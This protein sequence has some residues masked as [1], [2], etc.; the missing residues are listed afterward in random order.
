MAKILFSARRVA[1]VLSCAAITACAGPAYAPTSHYPSLPEAVPKPKPSVNGDL[2]YSNGS[3]LT[4]CHGTKCQVCK[5]IGGVPL[6]ISTSGSSAASSDIATG[7][8]VLVAD[9]SGQE[10]SEYNSSGT[11]IAV[12]ANP[13]FSAEDTAFGPNGEIAWT[14]NSSTSFGNGNITIVRGA[15]R[16]TVTGLFVN[17]YFGAFDKGGDFYNDGVTSSGTYPIGVVH[18]GSTTNEASKISGVIS[19]AGIAVALNGTVNIVDQSCLCIRIYKN[20]KPVGEVTLTGAAEP[21]SLALNRENTIV[22][23]TDE[24][25]GTVAAYPYPQGGMPVTVFNVPNAFG[26]GILPAPN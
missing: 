22:W 16:S 11:L 5:P 14:N 10:I 7:G 25:T 19:P 4:E 20:T 9:F 1:F 24:S 18:A 8:R 26:V 21:V 3:E 2:F 13:G 17:F 12:Y 15:K 6:G 23:V